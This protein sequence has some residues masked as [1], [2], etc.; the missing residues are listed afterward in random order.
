M[1]EMYRVCSNGALID[2]KVPHCNHFHLTN[3][4]THR[5][6]IT[7]YG[8]NLFSKK[9]NLNDKSSSSKLGLHYDVDFEL[10]SYEDIL[11]ENNPRIQLLKSMPKKINLNFTFMIK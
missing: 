3:D 6:K 4:P 9:F 5:I 11:D 2:I 8:L 10:V 7:W 1:Q